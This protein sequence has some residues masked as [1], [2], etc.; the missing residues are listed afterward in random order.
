METVSTQASA[1]R[2]WRTSL[3]RAGVGFGLWFLVGSDLLPH[4]F[5][6]MLPGPG[7]DLDAVTTT[8]LVVTAVVGIASFWLG[9]TAIERVIWP[10]TAAQPDWLVRGAT[11]FVCV[12][13]AYGVCLR[14]AIVVLRPLL[15]YDPGRSS[16]G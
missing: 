16:S 2:P 6:G 4:V 8:V 12:F 11:G 7:R 14:A 15:R 5:P 9:G 10:R 1:G 3:A 13:V